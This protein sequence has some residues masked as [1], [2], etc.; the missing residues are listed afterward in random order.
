MH[1]NV[2]IFED[3]LEA[4]SAIELETVRL[5]DKQF[6]VIAIKLYEH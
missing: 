1:A 4:S 3:F 2:Q 6:I 5:M